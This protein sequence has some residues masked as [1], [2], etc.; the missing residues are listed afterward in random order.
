MM[1]EF[2]PLIDATQLSRLR[3][4]ADLVVLDC[5]FDLADPDAGRRAWRKAHIPG[6]RYVDLEADL[7]APP[8]PESGRH[9]LPDARDAAQR[10][11]ALGISEA[12]RVVVYDAGPGAVA[13]RAWWMLEW[14]GHRQVA[15]LDGG[16]AAWTRAG[17]PVEAGEPPAAV[18]GSLAAAPRNDEIVSTAEL[19]E[20]GPG[21][22]TLPVVDARDERRFRGELEPIDPVAGHVPG[23]VNLPFVRLIGDDG[24][25]RS[26]EDIRA[27]FIEA[28]GG[29]PADEWAVMCG[30]GVTACHLVLGAEL[31]GLK[32]PRVY[33]GS[34]SEWLRDPARA[35]A[36]GE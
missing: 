20:A 7:S 21:A 11:E 24:R 6:A 32:R 3:G 25:F 27:L 5:R 36:T 12:S 22:T 14:L 2:G 1:A 17:L 19:V 15:L 28:L 9:P 34:W 23:A 33:I 31:A 35:I 4:A 30:S 29:A 16:F 18:T 10:F 26:G 13:A 8:S